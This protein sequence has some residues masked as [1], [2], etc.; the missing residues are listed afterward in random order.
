MTELRD[1][2]DGGAELAAEIADPVSVARRWEWPWPPGRIG[3][4]VYFLVLGI[5][6][7]TQG[8]PLDRIGQSAWILVGIAAAGIGR[9]WRQHV[10]MLVDWIP[11]LAALVLYDH[12]RGVAD[13]LGMPIR[14]GELVGAERW[15]F[16]G[17]LPTVW[18]QDRL[19]DPAEVHWW[20]VIVSV[21]YFSHF[22]VPWV[23]AAVFYIRARRRWSG[24]VRRVLLLSYA[25]LV[26]YV[27]LPAAPPW[28]AARVGEIPEQVERIATRGWDV[29]GL[30]SA[31]VWLSEAQAD[32]N[33]VAALPSLH[34]AFAL[35]V[36]VALWPLARRR[37]SRALVATFPVAMGF[38]LVYGGEHYVVDVLTGWLY[39]GAVVL[40]ARAWEQRAQP[41]GTWTT[42]T[43]PVA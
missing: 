31:G 43:G 25:G 16:G 34:S 13:T 42:A 9:S 3:L 35:L 12:T 17:E 36:A 14:V 11:L 37:A 40:A 30:R 33:Q 22:V 4:A 32:V 19:Y 27:L 15:L 6:C 41:S 26:T 8:I 5:F 1:A 2:P 29:L 7:V 21:V 18:L 28:Y 23:L 20:D 10:R 39:V 24:Y 38:T